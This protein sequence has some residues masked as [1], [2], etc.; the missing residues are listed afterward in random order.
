MTYNVC[1][2]YTFCAAPTKLLCAERG[3]ANRLTTTPPA[4][5][6]ATRA[7]VEHTCGR[8]RCCRHRVECCRDVRAS[9]LAVGFLC[10]EVVCT[11]SIP[12]TK[13][14]LHRR[15]LKSIDCIYAP[16][17]D[18]CSAPVPVLISSVLCLP[19]ILRITEACI[20]SGAGKTSVHSQAYLIRGSEL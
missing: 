19:G 14:R 3:N 10:V 4:A 8:A 6:T 5:M 17:G 18:V 15:T 7:L 11:L 12:T 1:S 9:C 2:F 13:P 16:S 20:F